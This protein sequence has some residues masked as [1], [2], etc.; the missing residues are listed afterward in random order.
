MRALIRMGYRVTSDREYPSLIK[1]GQANYNINFADEPIR[2]ASTDF[3]LWLA[4]GKEGLE[5]CLDNVKAWWTIVHNFEK[6]EEAIPE[7][8]TR[9]QEKNITVHYIPTREYI[10]EKGLHN[11]FENSLVIWAGAAALGIPY[12]QIHASFHH[13]YGKKE[14]LRPTNEACLK[15]GFEQISSWVLD[16]QVIEKTPQRMF[17][18][19]NTTLAM[20]AIHAGVRTYF[21]YP[22]SPSSSILGYFAKTAPET[23]IVVRQVEDEIS[24]IQ[25]SLGS[26]YAGTRSMTATSGWGFDLMTETISLSGMTEVPCVVAIAQRPGP[27]T[28]LPTWTAQGDLMLSIY[29]GHGEFARIVIGVSDP[30]SAFELTQHA[31]N[32]AE[33]YQVPVI[34]LTEKLIAENHQT[35]L[36]FEQWTIE[37]QRGLVT[38]ERELAAL[39]PSDRYKITDS[40]VSKRWVPTHSETI[41]Y[42]NGDE[43]HEDG[44]LNESE[45]AGDMILKRVRKTEA[46]KKALPDPV[47]YWKK[48]WKKLYIGRWSTLG[49]FQDIIDYE[50]PEWVSYLHIAY[51]FPV[52]AEFLEKICA[53][54]DEV[55]IIENNASGQLHTL[56]KTELSSNISLSNFKKRNGRQFSIQEVLSHINQ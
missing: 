47:L 35:V 15:A 13:R 26:M 54:F 18:D 5:Y 44:T 8:E 51:L 46:I 6:R 38:W 22:M 56:L 27:A 42:A 55:I 43:H 37:I 50:K 4:L 23:G 3:I 24:A 19:W 31:F 25:M 36:P 7:T 29:A 41:A 21:A 49:L 1:W 32:L 17:V 10:L 39:V 16:L 33:L 30:L 14:K 45:G 12:D 48:S 2:W 34:I 53:E 40:W 52:K 28:G 20:G 9:A 11:L